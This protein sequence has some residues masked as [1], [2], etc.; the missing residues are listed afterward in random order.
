MPSCNNPCFMMRFADTAVDI[1]LIYLLNDMILNELRIILVSPSHP[2]N[3]GAT[4][5]AMKNMGLSQLYLVN[6]ESFPHPLAS[7]RAAGADAVLE[8][9]VVVD[10]LEDALSDC[11][12]VFATS[13]RRR[14]LT[15]PQLDVRSSAELIAKNPQRPTAVV[16]GCERV[17]LSNEEL[18]RAHYHIYIPT[19]KAFSSLNLAQAVQVV[20]YELYMAQQQKPERPAASPRLATGDEV[21]GFYH[22]LEQ[23]LTEVDFLD[24]KQ[25]KMLMQRLRRLFNRAQLEQKE[26]NILRGILSAVDKQTQKGGGET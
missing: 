24:P 17:G 21:N 26:I 9:A 1:G 20:T 22:H 8:Q 7:A 16:F 14:N 12:W 15:W 6:P 2:G 19:D 13:A 18:A 23:T 3:I 11:E 5:R 25:P 10:N 4:A